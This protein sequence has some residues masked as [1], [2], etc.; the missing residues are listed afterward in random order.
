MLLMFLQP[1]K[2][3]SEPYNR[4]M[5]PT[6]MYPTVLLA[7]MMGLLV[8][9][10][11]R[12]ESEELPAQTGYT[13]VVNLMSEIQADRE[14]AAERLIAAGDVTLVPAIVD[15]YFYTP[16]LNRAEMTE[17]L[18]S[19]TG[20]EYSSYY[21]WVEYVGRTDT[22]SKER[23]IEWKLLMLRQKDP[24]YAKIFYPT[25][26]ARIRLEEIVSGG[27]PLDGIPSIDDPPMVPASKA[28]YLKK[29]EK[30]FGVEIEGE[31]RAYPH[32]FLSWHEMLNDEVGGVPVTLSYCTL[33]GSGIL[34]SGKTSGEPRTFGTSGLLYR[35][36]KLMYDRQSYTLWSNLTG[37]AVVGRLAGAERKLEVLPMTLTTWE[38]WRQSHPDTLVLDLKGV[39][40]AMSHLPYEFDYQPGAADEA[41]RGV[42]FPVWQK[43]AKMDRNEEIFAIEING[44]AK[45]YPVDEVL[46]RGILADE[47]GEEALVLVANPDSG[48]I[49]AYA[50]GGHT[51]KRGSSAME[52]VDETGS[53]WAVTEQALVPSG[54][55][56]PLPRYAQGH[57]A[58]WFGWYGFYPHTEVWD[59]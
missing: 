40:E 42:E 27:V 45:A 39:Q 44:A 13:L 46:Q 12:A 33:C 9:S 20:E 22:K 32:R 54:E 24:D 10:A 41:R 30:V 35:S 6:K 11:G 21:D 37:E 5:H 47:L 56:E 53:A 19:L 31:S 23:Y 16:T 26:P 15:A 50:S 7:T 55:G 59:G 48:A 1:S 36:N 8:L 3:R 17:V 18:Q 57:I 14:A 34:Y 43:S 29:G 28:K 2:K 49:R 4:E 58:Y 25:A 51:F 38:E 52:L